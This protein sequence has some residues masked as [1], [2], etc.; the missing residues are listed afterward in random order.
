MSDCK[1]KALTSNDFRVLKYLQ[2]LDANFCQGYEDLGDDFLVRLIQALEDNEDPAETVVGG[3][4]QLHPMSSPTTVVMADT[5]SITF[6][7]NAPG[8]A[9]QF[10]GTVNL[11]G[12]DFNALEMESDGLF[13]LKELNGLKTS[14][15]IATTILTNAAIPANSGSPLNVGLPSWTSSWGANIAVTNEHVRQ[16]RLMVELK[17]VSLEVH[18]LTGVNANIQAILFYR[19]NGDT[20]VAPSR[21]VTHF[22]SPAGYKVNQ[23]L[24]SLMY[25]RPSMAAE[26]TVT[27]E[28]ALALTEVGNVRNFHGTIAVKGVD[29]VATA[30]LKSGESWLT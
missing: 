13:V 8:P 26:E 15:A 17:D 14:S 6:N 25:V 29:I 9:Y 10:S 22:F 16:V 7:V 2:G 21:A 30:Y 19:V 18:N 1:R 27:V 12:D 28:F 5:S 24:C 20:W 4:G 3:D 23:T 11:S